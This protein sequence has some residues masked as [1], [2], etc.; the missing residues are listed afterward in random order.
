MKFRDLPPG[1]TMHTGGACP[2]SARKKRVEV[3]LRNGSHAGAEPVSA[4]TP[5]GW[6]ADGAQAVRW[7]HLPLHNAAA[8]FDVIGF[9]VL[10]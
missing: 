10:A 7:S 3:I 4:T 2:D 6:A 8:A 9:K 5:A 1:F